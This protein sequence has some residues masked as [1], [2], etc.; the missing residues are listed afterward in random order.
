MVQRFL[1]TV[2]TKKKEKKRTL[3]TFF[4]K[5]EPHPIQNL[6]SKSRSERNSIIQIILEAVP[7]KK[8]EKRTLETFFL[9]EEPHPIKTYLPRADP[10]E[11]PWSKGSYK[12][13]LQK[14]EKKER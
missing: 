8:E 4:L 5:E 13:F 12:P 10:R 6:S 11:I 9:K 3:V 1:E 14:R 7:T 2:P